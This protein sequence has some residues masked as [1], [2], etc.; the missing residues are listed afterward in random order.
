MEWNAN[1]AA[2]CFLSSKTVHIIDRHHIDKQP[3]VLRD[4]NA[5]TYCGVSI[6][7]A[8]QE[9]GEANIDCETCVEKVE[10]QQDYWKKFWS[11]AEGI[12]VFKIL[13]GLNRIEEEQRESSRKTDAF[14]REAQE[15]NKLL[16]D[17]LKHT[18]PVFT[19]ELPDDVLL[20]LIDYGSVGEVLLAFKMS[21]DTHEMLKTELGKTGY[22]L[23]GS[24]LISKGF[25]KANDPIF[26]RNRK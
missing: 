20:K 23:L 24:R 12:R 10:Y 21:E 4:V 17:C 16:Q 8:Y 2:I 11:S 1:L 14:I 15:F 18:E 6:G 25:L 19:L 7:E 22:A 9:C 3:S 13:T 5:K 26:S